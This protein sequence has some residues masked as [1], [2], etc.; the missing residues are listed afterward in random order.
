LNPSIDLLKVTKDLVVSMAYELK[1]EDE[2]VD[3]APEDD[4]LLFIQGH[5]HIIPG[6][7]T[8]I[9]GMAIGDSKHVSVKAEDGYGKYSEEDVV[10]LPRSEFPEDFPL[11]V[12]M[13]V[14]VEDDE[15]L[16]SSAFVE[17][18]TA[19]TVTLD[20]NHP[21]AGRDLEFDVKIIALRLPT[22]EELDHDHVH[23]EDHNHFDH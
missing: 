18:I 23:M 15:G 14:T 1:I 21:L 17:E 19:D 16:E 3:Q 11:E 12:D 2:I 8:A 6:L 20:F 22:S 10:E 5:G 13:E 7:E 9:E 4:P